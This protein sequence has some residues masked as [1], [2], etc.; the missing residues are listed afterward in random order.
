MSRPYPLS[1]T[2]AALLTAESVILADLFME[3]KDWDQVYQRVLDQNLFD[4]QKEATIRR[5]FN[6]LSL[7]LR[8]LEEDELE[9][10]AEGN[11]EVQRL[12]L[13]QAVCRDFLTG[14]VSG[15]T[16][17]INRRFV[18]GRNLEA[19]PG[20]MHLT[21]EQLGLSGDLDVVIPKSV[22]RLRRSGSGSRY[23]H[24]GLSLQELIVPVLTI[25]MLRKVD[26]RVR[27]VDV[28]ILGNTDIITNNQKSIRLLQRQPVV[29]KFTGRTLLIGFYDE[30]DQ[31]V[32][33]EI[34][35]VFDKEAKE[36][37]LRE[38][39]IQFTI[40]QVAASRANAR[41]TLRLR[42]PQGPEYLRKEFVLR[43]AFAR[44]F[45]L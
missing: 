15:D 41:V 6:E 8:S 28:E 14:K 23:V 5:L 31:L 40:S 22:N 20:L 30:E 3:M 13:W 24:G 26:E 9:L 33:N 27:P 1:F 38:D 4:R 29:D 35:M 36:D 10:V 2:G 21:T 19:G 34:K 37:R 7:R 45:D 11:T 42:D 25:R 17:K 43:I 32:S 12:L 39:T 44:D 18:L 16:E